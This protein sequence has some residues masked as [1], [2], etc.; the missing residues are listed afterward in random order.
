LQLLKGGISVLF[1]QAP[2]NHSEIH[3]MP[4]TRSQITVVFSAFALALPLVSMFASAGTVL[5]MLLAAVLTGLSCWRAGLR[6]PWPNRASIVALAVLLAWSAITAFWAFEPTE[7]LFLTLRLT[8]MFAAG[9]FLYAVAE[10]LDDSQRLIVGRWLTIGLLLSLAVLAGEIAFDYRLMALLRGPNAPSLTASLN[11]GAT[12]LAMLSWPVSA[13]LWQRGGRWQAVILPIAAGGILLASESQAAGLAMIIGAAT[14]LIA[15]TRRQA[16]RIFLGL[17]SVA[18]F[19]GAPFIAKR[20]YTLGWHQATWLPDTAQQRV[21]IWNTVA[22]LIARKPLFGWGFDASRVISR[23]AY[24]AADGSVGLAFLHP[25]NAMLQVLL[26]LGAVGG[27]IAVIVLLIVLARLERLPA[28]SRLFGQASFAA[29]LAIAGTAYGIWQYQWLATIFS[30][31]LLVYV[32][33]PAADT[34]T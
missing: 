24:T 20:L 18:L 22:G 23:Q 26:E 28:V 27:A 6:L 15:L 11:R 9:F 13:Y 32:T 10:T 29:T 5:L 21:E 34:E 25:H 8:A 16:G 14:L 2:S 4:D 17:T 12:A 31:A 3:R 1:P 33:R 7:S 30:T 19:A